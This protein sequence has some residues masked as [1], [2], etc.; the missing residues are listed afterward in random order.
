MVHC[1]TISALLCSSCV[2]AS[3]GLR[4]DKGLRVGAGSSP[5]QRT[6]SRVDFHTG[7]GTQEEKVPKKSTY[8]RSPSKQKKQPLQPYK[9]PVSKASR[10][11]AVSLTRAPKRKVVLEEQLLPGEDPN[12]RH[13]ELVPNPDKPH[14]WYDDWISGPSKDHF[15]VSDPICVR[16]V[17]RYGWKMNR[18]GGACKLLSQTLCGKGSYPVEQLGGG[19]GECLKHRKTCAVVGSSQHLLNATFGP[20][21][22]THDLIIRINSAPA[23]TDDESQYRSRFGLHVGTRTDARFVNMYGHMPEVEESTEPMCLFL[24]EPSIECGRFCWRNP[25]LCNISCDKTNDN[26]CAK[27]C[28]LRSLQCVGKAMKQA[29]WGNNHVFLD[30]IFGGITDQVMPHATAG[31]KAVIFALHTC[32]EVRVYGFGPTCGGELGLRYYRRRNLS[33]HPLNWHHYDDELRLMTDAATKGWDQIF[34]PGFKS[35]V[36]AK[37]LEVVLPK[38][39]NR[40]LALST[41]EKIK[42]M[43]RSFTRSPANSAG[44]DSHA[45]SGSTDSSSKDSSKDSSR[46]SGS[47]NS[48]AGNSGA[49]NSSVDLVPAGALAM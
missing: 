15:K 23:G 26:Y 5:E 48:G 14:V 8:R 24:H 49:G 27:T 22:D 33:D 25:G 45:E 42:K 3:M 32:E 29:N 37:S 36:R 44:G 17:G 1:S 9:W 2:V 18:T 30:S 40:V 43:T 35:W 47:G 19:H 13:R 46:D 11:K 7:G 31:F 38:C 6:V 4:V 34:P 20:I 21:I 16:D 41:K 10:K 28:N 12:D 39:V